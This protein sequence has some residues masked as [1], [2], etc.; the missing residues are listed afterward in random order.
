MKKYK[1]D[2]E[3]KQCSKRFS[4]EKECNVKPEETEAPVTSRE[5]SQCPNCLVQW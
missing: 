4:E 1:R 5:G 3:E 2:S